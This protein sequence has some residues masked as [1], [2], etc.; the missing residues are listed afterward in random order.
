MFGAKEGPNYRYRFTQNHDSYAIG[1][2]TGVLTNFAATLR[3]HPV[4]ESSVIITATSGSATLTVTDDGDGALVGD[5]GSG[6]NS[7][8]YDTGE[9][10]VTFS[11]APDLAASVTVEYRFDWETNRDNIPRMK[12]NIAS[13]SVT[14]EMRTLVASWFLAAAYDL[15]KAHNLKVEEILASG[16]AGEVRHEID[17]ENFQFVYDIA[18]SGTAAGTVSFSA[19]AATYY[20]LVQRYQEIVKVLT[21]GSNLIT[22]ATGRGTGNVIVAGLNVCNVLESCGPEFMKFE[23]DYAK[24]APNGPHRMGVFGGRWIVIKNPAYNSNRFV[25]A[26]KGQDWLDAGA[27]WMPYQPLLIVGPHY[28]ADDL[29]GR[30]GCIS[31]SALVETNGSFFVGGVLSNFS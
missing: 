15:S 24:G 23:V 31:Q 13:E 11:A 10:D 9:V 18:F 4:K 26:Y 16:V 20:S 29:G 30:L 1:T 14:A 28:L 5:V 25:L 27:V 21:A 17:V 22:A 7:I 6:D 8:D 19:A 12:I 3:F 2:G